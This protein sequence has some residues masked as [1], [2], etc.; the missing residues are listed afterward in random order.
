MSC[1]FV[2]IFI[3][4]VPWRRTL[5]GMPGWG[6]LPSG[7]RIVPSMVVSMSP[8]RATPMLAVGAVALGIFLPL[9]GASLRWCCS[10]PGS[11]SGGCPP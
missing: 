11:C 3:R 9:F 1:G 7:G 8:L 5:P 10:P 2:D 6:W 4:V